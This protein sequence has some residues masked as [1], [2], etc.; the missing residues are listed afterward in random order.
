MPQ[1]LVC[2]SVALY[3]GNTVV[4]GALPLGALPP[5]ASPASKPVV[6]PVMLPR[7]SA[8]PASSLPASLLP[9]TLPIPLPAAAPSAALLEGLIQ[10]VRWLAAAAEDISASLRILVSSPFMSVFCILR[11]TVL[12]VWPIHFG[13]L[14]GGFCWGFAGLWAQ[15]CA[16]LFGLWLTVVVCFLALGS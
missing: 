14:G 3:R 2:S 9:A 5:V 6:T 4:S 16:C 13:G 8:L 11:L 1:P 10:E 12:L 15:F 7:A